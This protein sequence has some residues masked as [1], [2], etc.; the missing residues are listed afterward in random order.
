MS[1]GQRILLCGVGGGGCAMLGSI[2]AG[3]DH[4]PDCAAVHSDAAELSAAG[5][6]RTVLLGGTVRLGVSAGGDAERGQRLAEASE[7]ELRALVEGRDLVI[8]VVALGGG[9]GSGAAPFLARMAR[10]SGALTLCFCATPLRFEGLQR[11]ANADQALHALRAAADA[12]VVFPNERLA[13]WFGGRTAVAE[14]FER[15]NQI[16]GRHVRA[17]WNVL[18]HPG[19]L[20][21]D[22]MDLRRMI[23]RGSGVL[24]VGYGE[25]EG[26]QR[27]EQAVEALVA[28]PLLEGGMVLAV[29]GG[30]LACIVGGPD[31][32]LDEM[33]R[34][35]EALRGRMRPDAEFQLG[36]AI[37]PA[38]AGRLAV[39]L[40]AVEHL[41]PAEE[42]P[43]PEPE[44]AAPAGGPR[45]P[46]RPARVR[47]ARAAQQEELPLQELQRGRF[48]N[49]TPTLY[50]GEDLDTPTFRRRKIDLA[51]L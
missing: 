22:L 37:S 26:E 46:G 14:A 50:E 31:L 19:L 24:S 16:I 21:T 20:R 42:A 17:V 36:A 29:S 9:T 8:L 15:I 51:A 43:A 1:D 28:S 13:E 10:Q 25:G 6:E 27:A 23:E 12:V 45:P 35:A 39:T 49:V 2:A 48:T 44:A 38:Y 30:L 47:R 18:R 32:R 3:W 33:E 7:T 4:A 40:L 5:V 34:V 11:Q 41:A